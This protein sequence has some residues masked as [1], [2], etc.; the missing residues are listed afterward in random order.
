MKPI[1]LGA[2]EGEGHEAVLCLGIAFLRWSSPWGLSLHSDLVCRLQQA[3][4][5]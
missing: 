4:H 3:G 1:R 2:F 5:A